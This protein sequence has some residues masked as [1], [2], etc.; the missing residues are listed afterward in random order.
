MKP[1]SYL[2]SSEKGGGTYSSEDSMWL[3][4]QESISDL[5]V[6]LSK[7]FMGVEILTFHQASAICLFIK[8]WEGVCVKERHGEWNRMEW[9]QRSV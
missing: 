8:P 7:A 2:V 5:F 9:K 1:R 4:L 6:F 3:H